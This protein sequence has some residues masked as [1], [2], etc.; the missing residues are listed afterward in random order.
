MPVKTKQM[1]NREDGIVY[2][3]LFPEV[4]QPSLL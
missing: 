4:Y 2:G 3:L 1:R